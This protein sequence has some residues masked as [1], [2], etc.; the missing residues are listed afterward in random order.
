MKN[1]RTAYVLLGMLSLAPKASGYDLHKA[2]E[3]NFGSFW[4]ESYGQNTP[5]MREP[6]SSSF[7]CG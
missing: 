4:G 6:M 3:E 5:N 2:I 7:M 1:N